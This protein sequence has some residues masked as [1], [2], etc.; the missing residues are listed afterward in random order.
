MIVDR[1]WDSAKKDVDACLSIPVKELNYQEF[2]AACLLRG[3]MHHR[4]GEEEVARMAWEQG[5]YSHW[6][7]QRGGNPP[8]GAPLTGMQVANAMLL[9]ALSGK[10]E[11]TEARHLLTGTLPVA[12]SG[13][14]ERLFRHYSHFIES[15]VVS[16]VRGERAWEVVRQMVFQEVTLQ[17]YIRDPVALLMLEMTHQGAAPGQ[18][19]DDEVELIW[20]LVQDALEEYNQQQISVPQLVQLAL[21]WRG[22]TSIFGWQGVAPSLAPR[23]R[24]P[25]AYI[26]GHRYRRLGR[27]KEAEMFFH[28]ARDNAEPDAPLHRLAS[29]QLRNES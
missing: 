10:M 4:Q 24:G 17:Q 2:S 29:T 1:N 19:N 21:T 12:G 13:M 5:I 26:F 3:F 7:A 20:Q 9:G 8:E 6:L 22:T 16:M 25:S 23:L 18:W 27:P 15:A 28:T 14:T 11:D